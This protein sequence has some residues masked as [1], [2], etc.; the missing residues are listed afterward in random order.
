MGTHVELENRNSE[1]VGA[2]VNEWKHDATVMGMKKEEPM[3]FAV[4]SK[5]EEP[6][7]REDDT[8]IGMKKEEK[9]DF[10]VPSKQEEPRARED[11]TVIGMKKEEKM[12]FSVPS[13]EEEPWAR[14]DDTKTYL[15][16][17]L[18][19]APASSFVD[20]EKKNN[21]NGNV[22]LNIG[23][24][25]IGGENKSV[26]CFDA[27]MTIIEFAA[28]TMGDVYVLSQTCKKWNSIINK[29]PNTANPIW[30]KIAR[31]FYG[32]NVFR[33][34]ESIDSGCKHDS[35]TEWRMLLYIESVAKHSIFRGGVGQILK[36]LVWIFRSD[37]IIP[38]KRITWKKES[39]HNGVRKRVKTTVYAEDYWQSLGVI[40]DNTREQGIDR[41]D[42]D[43]SEGSYVENLNMKCFF[44]HYLDH[45]Y[46]IANFVSECRI[47]HRWFQVF[48][49]REGSYCIYPPRAVKEGPLKGYE[50]HFKVI[51]LDL[52]VS[53][54][55]TQRLIIPP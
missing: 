33:R 14:E 24:T 47:I 6:R 35:N 9:M 2:N 50:G 23:T 5:V 48:G 43:F 15:S 13:K 17:F 55:F 36:L 37:N 45:R 11:D 52:D 42:V 19:T 51:V 49:I 26:I 34:L 4:P 21:D 29:I 32:Q 25:S 41:F 30:C 20:G 10:S 22:L 27:N 1:V 7:A 46:I 8:V 12:D 40:N 54:R 53:R 16:E 38:Y 28:S 31:R 3:D 39:E 44:V 18:T